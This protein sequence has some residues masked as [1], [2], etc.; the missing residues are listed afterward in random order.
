[1]S[2]TEQNLSHT[3]EARAIRALIADDDPAIRLVLRHRLEAEGWRVE[4]AADS[5]A[6]LEALHKGRFDVALVD[7]IMP[8]VGG[9]EVLTTARE[10]GCTTPIVVI[11]AAST[12]NNAIEA[13]KR[14]GARRPDEAIREPRPGGDY[15]APRRPRPRAGLRTGKES[16]KN[17]TAS[18]SAAELSGT[19]RRCRRSTNSSAGRSNDKIDVVLV[20]GESGTGKELL[21]QTIHTWSRAPRAVHP[22]QLPGH[23]GRPGRERTV[24]PRAG[25]FTG[26]VTR[27]TASS[28]R[29]RVARCSWTRSATCRSSSAQAVARA[30]GT[31]IHSGRRGRDPAPVSPGD[32]RDQPDLER[33]VEAAIF[34]KISTFACGSS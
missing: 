20:W 31:G 26:A 16:S 25:A 4:E 19:A 9:L 23:P 30:P 12:T 18:W 7:I 29:R 21:A 15:G 1:M 33:A 22:R 3:D 17:S 24:R 32:R 6:A 8:G 28:R 34:A 5:G 11:T 10:Q 14:G 2:E 13:L 27:R